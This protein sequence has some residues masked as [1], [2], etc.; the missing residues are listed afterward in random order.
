MG[1]AASEFC[2]PL[3]GK[4]SR[5]DILQEDLHG[6]ADLGTNDSFSTGEVSVLGGV[7]DRISHIR[8]PPLIDEVDDQFDFVKAFKICHLRWITRC[9]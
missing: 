5:L 9:Y 7:A 4:L 8:Q 2:D 6:L 3:V 1:H